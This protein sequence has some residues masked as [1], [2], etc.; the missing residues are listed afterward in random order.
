MLID[1]EHK[2]CSKNRGTR[3]INGK[4]KK[5]IKHERASKKGN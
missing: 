1:I 2:K 5:I 4:I 3:Y